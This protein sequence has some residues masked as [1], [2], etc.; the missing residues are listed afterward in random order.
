MTTDEAAKY[1]KKHNEEEVVVCPDCDAD[2][3][4]QACEYEQRQKVC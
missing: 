2:I 4:E 1:A 3:Y